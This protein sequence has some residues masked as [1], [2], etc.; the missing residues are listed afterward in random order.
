MSDFDSIKRVTVFFFPAIVILGSLEAPGMPLVV[1][2]A[3]IC[4]I[5]LGIPM[6]VYGYKALERYKNAFDYEPVELWGKK[7]NG[8]GVRQR[9]TGI[10]TTGLGLFLSGL[11]LL[12]ITIMDMKRS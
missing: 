8:R 3:S 1:L 12:V 7:R 11:I 4:F 10:S 5:A 9:L 2:T 6:S